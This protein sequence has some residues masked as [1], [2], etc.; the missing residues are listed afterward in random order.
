MGNRIIEFLRKNWKAVTLILI[1]LFLIGMVFFQDKKINKL[2]E[3]LIKKQQ[4]IEIIIPDTM[5]N[6][7]N[8]RLI[9]IETHLFDLE[10]DLELVSNQKNRRFKE[11]NNILKE[12]TYEK[13]NISITTDSG[14][15]DSKISELLENSNRR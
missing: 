1:A 4:P 12:L 5:F 13:N 8:E 9:Q 10:Y 7:M 3:A 6:T 11:L 14:E 2:Q 15:L